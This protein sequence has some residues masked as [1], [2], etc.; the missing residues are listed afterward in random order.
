[1]TGQ[2]EVAP[3]EL[4][5]GGMKF[6]LSQGGK[7]H[8]LILLIPCYEEPHEGWLVSEHMP[9]DKLKRRASG[10]WFPTRELALGKTERLITTR[11]QIGIP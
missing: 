2:F 11:Q 10:N 5:N 6:F 1:M 7:K 8:W 3:E 4:A 9:N